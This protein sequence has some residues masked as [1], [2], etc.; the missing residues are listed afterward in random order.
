M[1]F[2]I[3]CPSYLGNY[4]TAAKD[5]DKKIVRMI[6]SVMGQTFTNFELIIIADG[7]KKTVDICK[8]YLYEYMPKIRILEIPKQKTWSGLVRNA[9]IFNAVGDIITYVDID[10]ILGCNHL[11]II[12]DNFGDSDWVWYDHLI[13]SMKDNKF[14]TY[15]TN[16]KV[17]GQCGTSSVSHL[18]SLNAYWVNHSYSHDLA[19]IK[20]LMALSPNYKKIPQTEYMVC[21]TPHGID[22]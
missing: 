11:Q 19:F 4:N 9:G 8:P 18:R 2:S 15:R 10:D 3:I 20:T 12:N 17:H 14:V 1:M 22:Y 16:I 6:E 21:H 7:C 5:R 13:Y